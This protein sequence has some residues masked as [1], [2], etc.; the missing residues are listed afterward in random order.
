MLRNAVSALWRRIRGVSPQRSGGLGFWLYPEGPG[1]QD[2]AHS[3]IVV[4]FYEWS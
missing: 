3:P 4:L 1:D 2:R